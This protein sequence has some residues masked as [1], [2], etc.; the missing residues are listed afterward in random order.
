M[1]YRFIHGVERRWMTRPGTVRRASYDHFMH[2]LAHDLRN[3]INSILLMAQLL[4][5]SGGSPE[6]TRIALRIQRQCQELSS[7]VDRAAQS[8]PE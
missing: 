6:A 5:E 3:P 8:V 4:E 7:I 1:K 2:R